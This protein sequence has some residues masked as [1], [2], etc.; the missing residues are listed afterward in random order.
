MTFTFELKGC[1]LAWPKCIVRYTTSTLIS[2]VVDPWRPN[3]RVEARRVKL[4]GCEELE[5]TKI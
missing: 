1:Y 4:A 3:S 2:I 5:I